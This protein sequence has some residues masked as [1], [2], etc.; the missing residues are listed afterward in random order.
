VSTFELELFGTKRFETQRFEA[1]LFERPSS[2][3]PRGRLWRLHSSLAGIESCLSKGCAQRDQS[4]G[5]SRARVLSQRRRAGARRA[6]RILFKKMMKQHCSEQCYAGKSGARKHSA[7]PGVNTG[8]LGL[9]Q[10]N[11]NMWS[12]DQFP[13]DRRIGQS[14]RNGE[15]GLRRGDSIRRQKFPTS[16]AKMKLAGGN[17]SARAEVLDMLGAVNPQDPAA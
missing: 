16:R 17:N 1:K 2:S 7:R 11:M 9:G 12:H 15:Y 10:L 5:R 6:A 13:C 14:I 4:P 8:L 3:I